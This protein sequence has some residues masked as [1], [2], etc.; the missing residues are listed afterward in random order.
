MYP[1]LLEIGERSV[2]SWNVKVYNPGKI[3]IGKNTVISQYRHLCAATHDYDSPNFQLL[4]QPIAIGSNVWI[5]ADA[6]IG[7][8]VRIGD[9]AVVAAR[10]VV[11]RDVASVT[12]VAGNPARVV[13]ELDAVPPMMYPN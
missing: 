6:F 11:V 12:L 4:K 10:A 8:G 9:G 1:W 7:P 2:I 5:A 3:T 13:K